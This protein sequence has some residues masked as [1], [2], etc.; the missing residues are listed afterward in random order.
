MRL[1]LWKVAPP[2]TAA[3]VIMFSLDC[4]RAHR[5]QLRRVRELF[6]VSWVSEYFKLAV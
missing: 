3:H 1:D 2:H 6:H 5:Y 4:R